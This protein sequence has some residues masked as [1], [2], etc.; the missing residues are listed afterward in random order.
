MD[1]ITVNGQ[2]PQD[3]SVITVKANGDT[4]LKY[5]MPEAEYMY[6]CS[7]TAIGM[8]LG[9]YDLYG[10]TLDGAFY[11]MSNVIEGTISVDSRGTGDGNIY[12]MADD[13]VL[14]KF[15]ASESFVE[16]FYET[17]P[18]D[19]LPYTFVDGDPAKGLNISVFDCLADWLGTGQHYRG[20]DDLSTAYYYMTLNEVSQ[21][22]YN[23][24]EGELKVPI[25]Y[26]DFKY[27]LNE[28]VKTRGLILD[29][30]KTASI[31][32]NDFSFERYCEE[33]DAGRPILISVRS[34]KLGG[35][36]VIGYGYNKETRELIFDDTYE[37]DRRIAWDGTFEYAGASDWK[38][39][40]FS[41][42]V[43][44]VSSMTP[45]ENPDPDP[46]SGYVPG[47]WTSDMEEA[48]AYAKEHNVPIL[49]YFGNVETCGYCRKLND[50]VFS[51]AEFGEYTQSGAIVLV[52]N[53][54]NS[55]LDYGGAIPTCFILDA[56][57]KELGKKVGYS[58]A[59]DWL[60]WF[61]GLVDL[62]EDDPSKTCNLKVAASVLAA[63]KGASQNDK[64]YKDN[65]NLYLSAKVVNDGS[66]NIESAFTVTVSVD[67]KVIKTLNV[68]GLNAGEAYEIKD[69]DLGIFAKGDHT[70]VIVADA[71]KVIDESNEN[72]NTATQKFTVESMADEPTVS[73]IIDVTGKSELL[74]L[75]IV[76]GGEARVSAGGMV[77]STT[78]SSG[79]KLTVGVNGVAA[80]TTVLTGGLIQ[81]AGGNALTTVLK[82]GSARVESGVLNGITIQDG[83]TA[84]AT[85]KGVVS[86]AIV[87]ENSLLALGSGAVSR[88]VQ[89]LSGGKLE[90]AAG[91]SITDISIA[92]GASASVAG[93]LAGSISTAGNLTLSVNSKLDK[94]AEFKID[95]TQKIAN[96]KE[97]SVSG[98]AAFKDSAAL[99]IVVSPDQNSG[100]YYI[101]N[102]GDKFTGSFTVCNTNGLCAASKLG[103]S[104]TVSIGGVTASLNVVSGALI[105]DV[106]PQELSNNVI[107]D[108]E[109]TLT[110][111]Q[112]I[113]PVEIGSNGKL[114]VNNGARVIDT[115][116]LANGTA[117]I[118]SGGIAQTTMVRSGG[119]LEAAGLLSNLTVNNGGNVVLTSGAVLT[120]SITL[121]DGANI[122]AAQGSCITISLNKTTAQDLFINDLKLIS[123]NYT[124][125]V[126]VDKDLAQGTYSLA[127]GAE[128]FSGKITICA[129]SNSACS[130]LTLNTS[131][132]VIDGMSYT[133]AVS[134]GILQFTMEKY[135][136][137]EELAKIGV[138]VYS[139]G[140]LVSHVDSVDSAVVSSG[141]KLVANRGGAIN[142]A[143]IQNGGQV[144]VYSGAVLNNAEL[145]QGGYLGI[146]KGAAASNTTIAVGGKLTVWGGGVLSG[147]IVNNKAAITLSSG[148]AAQ[149]TDI[150]TGGAV[151]VYSGAAVSQATLRANAYLGIGKGA[152]ANKTTIATGGK[153][154]VWGGGKV[155]NSLIESKGTITLSSGAVA[156]ATDIGV[157]GAMHIY[158]GATAN[159]TE[160]AKS[161]YLGIGNG[162]AANNTTIAAGGKL[163]VWGGGKVNSSL[164][165]SQGTIIL[166][167]GA[168]ADGA[169]LAKGG[170]LHV[171]N[172]AK[173]AGIEL[174]SGAAMGVGKN[175]TLKSAAVAR[176]ASLT[177]YSGALLKGENTFAGNITIKGDVDASGA[178]I[179]LDL[180]SRKISDQV[181]ITNI[182]HVSEASISINV[183]A[184]QN[185]G[186]YWLAKGGSFAGT[187]D[188][189]I[190]GTKKGSVS[191][192]SSLSDSGKLYSLERS[193]NDYLL[194]IS[195]AAALD[196]AM[197][198]C[199]ND[200][201]LTGTDSICKGLL[202]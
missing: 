116:I 188:L 67:G 1:T 191:L 60:E 144:H 11:D 112:R 33:I 160:V 41:T 114:Y 198:V 16:R 107:V 155:N 42:V 145:Q 95:I 59:Q 94:N 110:S 85:N 78:V 125:K 96:V 117:V 87:K 146:G 138:N 161:A 162:A 8:L 48:L 131:G 18:E 26:I 184:S 99:Y 157:G 9:Y 56:N 182:Q 108:R 181:I 178:V 61:M 53:P 64:N 50:E 14:A 199:D 196:Q 23:S 159:L 31:E 77:G 72:D 129:G 176:G 187:M 44:D 179:K 193:G 90:A 7:A 115:N 40:G 123:G 195:D 154:T 185:K 200:F 66:D 120:G 197:A 82:G 57:G 194:R 22:T 62:P 172:G 177:L 126:T 97:F 71:G 51:S 21:S 132:V 5:T 121:E 143:T 37:T 201:T 130:Q 165:E 140:K 36:M 68:S 39:S 19:E 79:G 34:E 133:A 3:T 109:V 111:G 170:T 163:T 175:G 63:T 152:V 75:Q 74:G 58:N 149:D 101:A 76:D 168:A 49:V 91:T 73:D 148:A 173:A 24:T 69:L 141:M 127:A 142:S 171:Y 54:E 12:D 29:G 52:K 100:K 136:S 65:T 166:S 47:E 103:I 98:L 84:S 10:Y 137:P 122:T 158:S 164:I 81:V 135:V 83:G 202:A 102:D 104:G 180:S 6:G 113:S 86:Q 20:G 2:I 15:I 25:K 92:A 186:I 190:D 192:K 153:L 167:S 156:N 128:N 88:D 147:S 105:F 150:L 80:T 183:N 174:I 35:H 106:A 124:L 38:L 13:S 55:N 32:K 43:F 189:C 30:K 70:V 119:R 93:T 45:G 139:A 28:Y 17:N 169:T 118:K 134:G 4:L 151:H 89:I 27:G 46:G